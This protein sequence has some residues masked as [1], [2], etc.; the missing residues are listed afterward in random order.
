MGEEAVSLYMVTNWEL[1][2][3]LYTV[4]FQTLHHYV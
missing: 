4:T 3:Q 1:I 2:E